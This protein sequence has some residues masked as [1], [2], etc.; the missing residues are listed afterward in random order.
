MTRTQHLSGR[1]AFKVIST[2]AMA[3][4][5]NGLL[6]AGPGSP[7]SGYGLNYERCH[8]WRGALLQVQYS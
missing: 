7:R 1:D 4:L 8:E 2:A 6:A 5:L 3:V